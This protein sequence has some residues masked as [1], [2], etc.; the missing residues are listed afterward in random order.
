MPYHKPTLISWESR[1]TRKKNTMSNEWQEKNVAKKNP[2]AIGNM[3]YSQC[4]RQRRCQ[5]VA[6]YTSGDKSEQTLL[7]TDFHYVEIWFALCDS[8]IFIILIRCG[9]EMHFYNDLASSFDALLLLGPSQFYCCQ[10][11]SVYGNV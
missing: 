5:V 3:M 2:F 1:G 9:A 7:N 4:R 11:L 8:G 6:S 10:Q